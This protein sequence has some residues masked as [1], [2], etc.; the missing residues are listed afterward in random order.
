MKAS[1]KS[2]LLLLVGIILVGISLY[3]LLR[4]H[5]D[6]AMI[7]IGN[8]EDNTSLFYLVIGLALAF[9]GVMGFIREAQKQGK[10]NNIY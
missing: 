8:G 1:I 3:D 9:M 5:E 4:D 10:R 6:E 7:T 2:S